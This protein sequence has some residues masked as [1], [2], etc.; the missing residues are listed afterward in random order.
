MHDDEKKCY[1]E[2]NKYYV[3]IFKSFTIHKSLQV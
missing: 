2:A 3:I 1:V